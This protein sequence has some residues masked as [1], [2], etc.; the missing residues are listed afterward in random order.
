MYKRQGLA[1]DVTMVIGTGYVPGHAAMALALLRE[2][3]GVRALFQRR[4][5]A[6]G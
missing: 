5:A 6:E 3:P 1:A 2:V 4:L